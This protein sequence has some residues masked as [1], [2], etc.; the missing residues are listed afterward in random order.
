MGEAKLRGSR[1]ERIAQAIVK[2]EADLEAAAHA[3]AAVEQEKAAKVAAMPPAERQRFI[4][5][6]RSHRMTGVNLVGL[7]LALAAVNTDPRSSDE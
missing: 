6:E 7:M 4:R 5:R 1:D 3:K 2:Y